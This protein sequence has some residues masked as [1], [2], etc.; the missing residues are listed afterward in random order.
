M[1]LNWISMQPVKQLLSLIQIWDFVA[2]F[3]LQ[4]HLHKK[5]V[6]FF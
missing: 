2:C 3:S 6:W 1:E 4:N 5:V